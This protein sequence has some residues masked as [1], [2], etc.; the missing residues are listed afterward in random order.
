MRCCACYRCGFLA[1]KVSS[2]VYIVNYGHI[3]WTLC[4][5][6]QGRQDPWLFSSPKGFREQNH[7]ENTGLYAVVVEKHDVK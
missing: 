6:E 1:I 5:R 7:L 3:I 2:Y 4:L